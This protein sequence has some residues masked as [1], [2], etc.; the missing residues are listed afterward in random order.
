MVN[1]LPLQWGVCGGQSEMCNVCELTQPTPFSSAKVPVP[2]QFGGHLQLC[3]SSVLAPFKP[4]MCYLQVPVA[5]QRA[6][7][8]P[9]TVRGTR[10]HHNAC[11]VYGLNARH[12]AR[13]CI[14]PAC[15]MYGL[16]VLT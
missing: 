3:F 8:L 4:W 2:E 16:N 6:S 11:V 1:I 13:G 15:V 9:D 14:I 7:L 5:E 12:V 10:V